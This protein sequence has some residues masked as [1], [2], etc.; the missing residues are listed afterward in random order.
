MSL[1]MSVC[2]GS[3]LCENVKAERV[4]HNLWKGEPPLLPYLVLD[5]LQNNV[6]AHLR[7]TTGIRMASQ[8]DGYVPTSR[9]SA[10]RPIPDPEQNRA[11][12]TVCPQFSNLITSAVGTLQ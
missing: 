8:F 6:F 4:D 5:P 12:Q 2:N 1:V 9:H 7:S 11:D 3:R 10:R